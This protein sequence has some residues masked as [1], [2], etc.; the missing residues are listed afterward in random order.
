MKFLQTTKPARSSK[1][2][3]VY[4]HRGA[5][6]DFTEMSI[7]AFTGAVKQG[8]DGFECDVRLTKDGTLV[9]WHDEDL[10]RITS[11][12][13]KIAELTYSDVKNIFP[14][15]TVQELLELAIKEKKNIAFETKHPVPTKLAVEKELVKVLDSRKVSIERAGIHISIM[16]FSWWAVAKLMRSKWPAV[17]LVYNT[18]GLKR[19]ISKTVAIELEQIRNDPKIVS[20]LHAKGRRVYVWTINTHEDARLVTKAGVDVIITDYPRIIRE[21]LQ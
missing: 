21:V 10:T 5:S 7:E 8:A 14:I 6:G 18:P 3:L 17:T 9:L 19:A 1:Q 4:A 20:R 11:C 15:L 16:S 12:D 13:G 2:P